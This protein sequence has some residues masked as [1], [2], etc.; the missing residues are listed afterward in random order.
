MKRKRANKKGKTKKKPK[1]ASA[2][3]VASNAVSLNA[4]DNSGLNEFDNEDIDSGVDAGTESTPSPSRGASQ[5]E[6]VAKS[7]DLAPEIR[8]N[9]H[10]L[11]KAVYTR[12]KVKIKTSKNLESQNTSKDVRALSDTEKSNQPVGSD[13][14]VGPSEKMEDSA[15]SLSETNGVV[16]GNISKKSVGIKIKASRGL[17][18]SSMSPCSNSEPMKV[19]KVE[20]KDTESIHQESQYNEQEL[21]AALEVIRRV[22]KMDAAE[23]FNVPVNPVALGIPDYFDVIDTPMDFGT[24]C[25]NLEKGTKY[26]SSEDV[27]KD[28][29]YIWDNCYKYNNKGDYI[30]DLMK[31]VKKSF[32]KYWTALGLYTTD[33]PQ[34]TS[35]HESNPPKDLTPPSEGNTSANGGAVILSGKK[36][37]G[38]KK[39]KEGCMCAICIMMRR[40]QEREEI[41]RLMEGPTEGSD[42]SVGEDMKPEGNSHGESPFG[43]YASSNIENSP[44]AD[45][46]ETERKSQDMKL[47][48][49]RNFYGLQSDDGNTVPGKQESPQDL[50]STQ[51]SSEEN[52]LHIQTAHGNCSNDAQKGT[53]KQNDEGKHKEL[54][55]KHQRAKMLEN[56]RYLDNPM[57]LELY[58]TL[59]ADNS[60]SVWNGPRSLLGCHNPG[61][62]RRSTFSSAISSF[63]K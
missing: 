1:L 61:S 25:S 2:N 30:V 21:K 16:S 46:T 52:A 13:K 22:M 17:G 45:N 9:N 40:R 39:H 47:G 42:D 14:Q 43:E 59:F 48:H 18:S 15:N 3:E 60:E 51:K 38:L 32:T 53:S 4:E 35:G 55:D 12:V 41:A 63:M 23:P 36:F 11:V 50:Q 37:H 8:Q 19:E 49:L 54:L 56:L 27:F 20:K 57:L 58:G 34:E 10:T 7:V 62:A 6:T 28:V 33:Q 5:P 26:K 24:I 29:Q 31:R 44:D